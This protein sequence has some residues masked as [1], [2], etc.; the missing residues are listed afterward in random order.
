MNTIRFDRHPATITLGDGISMASR[1][2]T[3]T[4]EWWAIPVVALAIV[5]GLLN[6]LA[7]NANNIV[8]RDVPSSSDLNGLNG[9]IGGF[10]GLGAVLTVAGVV[11]GWF[12]AALAIHGLRGRPITVDWVVGA[13]LRSLAGSILLAAISIGAFVAFAI[14]AVITQGILL[15]ALV[16]LVPAAIYVVI[17]FFFWTLAIFDGA[18]ITDSFRVSWSLSE[19]AVLRMLGWGI[20]FVLLEFIIGIGVRVVTL[21]LAGVPA[22]ATFVSQ[23][24]NG[25]LS[26]FTLF[27]TAILYESQRWTRMPPAYGQ[28][29]AAAPTPP[30]AMPGAPAPGGYPPSAGYPMS[31]YPS[32]P[33]YPAGTGYPAAPV[34]PNAPPPAP[35][36]YGQAT[37]ATTASGSPQ[38]LVPWGP[39]PPQTAWTPTPP[40][41]WVAAPPTT[42][43]ASASASASASSSAYQPLAGNPFAPPASAEATAPS[44][45]TETPPAPTDESP[46]EPYAPPPA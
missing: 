39:V 11:V 45:P 32:S 5:G 42:A 35:S 16:G 31:G 1:Y 41:G 29:V 3:A 2:L 17:R 13:G 38:P 46:T 7:T 6:G 24:A 19:G 33:S 23:L 10:L 37:P 22:I 40:P 30:W 8:I 4:W 20:A 36:M 34:D 21:P 9:F 15:I 12:Y 26:V 44:S 27:G 25:A 28:P 43:P 18:G 14:L